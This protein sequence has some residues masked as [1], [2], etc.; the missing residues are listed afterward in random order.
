[1]KRILLPALLLILAVACQK[2]Y[3][4]ATSLQEMGSF[5]GKV[6]V[7]DR[8]IKF[9]I[10]SDESETPLKDA[11]E[12]VFVKFDIMRPNSDGYDIVVRSWLIP[13]VKDWRK[14]SS[15]TQDDDFGNDPIRVNGGW[16]GGGYM[17]MEVVIYFLPESE[18]RHLVNL[19]LEDTPPDPDT[20][21]FTMMHNAYGEVPSPQSLKEEDPEVKYS[22]GVS[23]VCFPTEGMIPA[24]KEEMPF[25]ISSTWYAVDDDGNYLLKEQSTVGMLRS[26]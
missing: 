7:S 26:R 10:V 13:L 24:D 2:D 12:R 3:M 23:T 1:M 8:G 15:L 18:T 5:D 9:N 20:L 6:F 17:N 4:M 11:A 19:V 21:R 22:R 16:I 14:R 25:K